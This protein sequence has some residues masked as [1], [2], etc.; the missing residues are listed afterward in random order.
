MDFVDDKKTVEHCESSPL[1]MF[2]VSSNVLTAAWSVALG[3]TP[4][5]SFMSITSEKTPKSRGGWMGQTQDF[6]AGD[7]GN[8]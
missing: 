8:V 7:E 5:A 6:Q 1:K 2:D 3:F 4:P